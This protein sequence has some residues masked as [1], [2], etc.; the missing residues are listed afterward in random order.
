MKMSKIRFGLLATTSFCGALMAQFAAPVMGGSA[1]A[2]EAE[3]TTVVVT[4][5]RI[6]RKELTS[7][8]PIATLGEAAL[9]ELGTTNTET[10]IN[11]LPQAIPGVTGTVNNGNGGLATVNLR[12]LGSNRTLVLIDGKRMTPTSGGGS[13]D[14]NL[15]PPALI[16]EIQVLTGGASATYGSDAIAGVVNF[17]YKKNFS[18]LEANVGHSVT[19]LGDA[20]TYSADLTMGANFDGGR[21]N[22]TLSLGYNKREALLQGERG[23]RMNFAYGEG[24][25]AAARCLIVSGSG[26]NVDTQIGNSINFGAPVPNGASVSTTNPNLAFGNFNTDGT[27]RPYI[28]GTVSPN[29]TYNFAPINY[30]QVPQDRYS[31][32]ALARYDINEGL[33]AYARASFVNSQVDI[34]LAETPIGGRT[35]RITLDNNP[36]IAASAKTLL[37]Q[38]RVGSDPDVDADGLADEISVT[39]NRRL[40]EVGPRR[41]NFDFN[42]FQMLMGLK[43]DLN[44]VNGSWEGF[45][46]YGRVTL[47]QITEGDISLTRLQQ[48]LRVTSTGACTDTT[49]GCVGVNIFGRNN[50][51]AAAANFLRTRISAT[52]SFEQITTGLS[53]TGDTANLFSLPAGPIGFAGG[54]EYRSDAFEFAPSQD[55]ATGNL[56]GFNSSPPV[57]GD[58]DVYEYFGELLIPVVRDVPLMQELNLE[59]AARSSDYNVLK[60]AVNSYKVAG[61][62]MV[63]DQLRLR[64]SYNES[65]RAPSVTELYSAQ[66]N[67]FPTATDHCSANRTALATPALN[68]ARDAVCIATGVP[69]GSVGGFPA[70][71]QVQQ[72]S[73]GNPNLRPETA[74]TTSYGFVYRPSYVPNLTVIM[75][76]YKISMIDRIASFGGGAANVLNVCY[77][78]VQNASSPY[79][80]AVTR[81]SGGNVDKVFVTLQN[82]ASSENEGVDLDVAYKFD[83]KNVGLTNWGD[84]SVRTLISQTMK[85]DVKPDE[86]SPNIA[87]TGLFGATCGDPTPEYKAYTTFKWGMGDWDVSWN[88]N[89][90]SSVTD[91]APTSVRTIEEVGSKNYHNLTVVKE[92]NDNVKLSVGVRNLTHESYPIMGANASSS[93][94]G[95]PATYD[96]LGRTFWANIGLK[97]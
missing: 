82:A 7:T 59:L 1:M 83:L 50:I 31:M 22:A 56:V 90:L 20:K 35:L 67:G 66:S 52:Q 37:N 36:F 91:D 49:G 94:N 38:L 2:Q 42:S 21:G 43:G 81:T 73:G 71:A 3:P 65:T 76:Y 25:T 15:I 27:L 34:Q 63:N 88:W 77:N 54:F 33:E 92:L 44:A 18:G 48:G 85:R 79:C 5:S 75:D 41:Q 11:N 30:M 72:I 9:K 64:A 70:N 89:Y 51:S 93:N 10:L 68:A 13:V 84:L 55:L 96:V 47:G 62:W 97:F 29:D 80:Q 19:G 86:V 32:T 14:L 24:C 28:G 61:D 45:L 69:S 60:D 40:S 12:G 17:I 39:V 53:F 95:Y 87:C 74:E 16:K 6:V 78:I 23:G 4:G 58:I 8:A 26:A 46:Q 57:A